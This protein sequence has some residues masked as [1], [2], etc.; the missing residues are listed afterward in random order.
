MN[1]FTLLKAKQPMWTHFPMS[2]STEN[3]LRLSSIYWRK[4]TPLEWHTRA[5]VTQSLLWLL[6]FYICA[7]VA[8]NCWFSLHI[9]VV[10]YVHGI[11]CLLSFSLCL[12]HIHSFQHSPL[13]GSVPW[14][15]QVGLHVLP[16]ASPFISQ[17]L[18]LPLYHDC[19]RDL[20]FH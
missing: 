20:F 17:S 15:A 1:T 9:D 4:S 16:S 19:F 11:L 13:P 12:A 7:P 3:T 14:S 6:L 5:S 8:P 18:D 2:Y 10:S